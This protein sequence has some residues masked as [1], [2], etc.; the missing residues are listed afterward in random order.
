[1]LA[2]IS[3]QLRKGKNGRRDIPLLMLFETTG[4]CRDVRFKGLVVPAPRAGWL[5]VERRTTSGGVIAN[6]RAQL[7]PMRIGTVSRLWLSDVQAGQSRTPNAPAEWTR[8]VDT[9]Q[10]N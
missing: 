7:T 2:D 9:G 1:M 8:W 6:Y 3:A 4:H 10:I 5:Q